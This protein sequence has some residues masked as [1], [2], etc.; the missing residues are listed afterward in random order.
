M[1]ADPLRTPYPQQLLQAG[2]LDEA[3]A[4][5]QRAVRGARV[6][7]PAHGFLAAVLL[8]LH[9]SVEAEEVIGHALEL[10]GGEA[11]AY[12]GLAYV[13]MALGQHARA[14]A[15]YRRASELAPGEPRFWYNLACSERSLGRLIE[16]EAACDRA[17]AMDATQYPTYLLRS[18]LR[19]QAPDA[20]H[21]AELEARLE[22][23]DTDYRAKVFLGYALAKELDDLGRFDEAFRWFANA[24]R[25]R[26]A[27]LVYDVATDE[28]KLARIAAVYTSE[29]C[30]PSTPEPGAERRVDSARHIFIVG[31]PRSGTTLVERI[32]M[33]LSGVRSNGET[34]N[35]S[36]ALLAAARGSGDVFAQAAAADAVRV[37]A[38]YTELADSGVPAARIIEKLPLNY[39]YVGAI[40]HA[41]PQAQILLVRRSPLDS[42]FAMYRTLFAGGYPFSYDLE[43]LGRYYA[44]YEQLLDHWRTILGSRLHEIVYEDLVREPQRIGAAVA[45]SCRLTWNDAAIDIQQNRAASLTASAAQI[46]RPIYGS[47]SG[48]WRHYRAHLEVLIATLRARGVPLPA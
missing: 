5:A 35:F 40:H 28:R 3:L 44:A 17:I 41:L 32:L 24:A 16:A 25:T 31:L 22:R 2:R 1:S 8:R 23:A 33:G 30:R 39:L 42:C 29:A 47:S 12:D 36:R 21:V 9:R 46:R 14:N 27:R 15:L 4:F 43:E 6:C 45:R 37:A 20:N 18:E 13:S 34:D 10:A 19:V 7:L 48:R 11:D 38:G 26:R